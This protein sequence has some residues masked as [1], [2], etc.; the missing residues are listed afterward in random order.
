[1]LLIATFA[2]FN[3]YK[4]FTVHQ[5]TTLADPSNGRPRITTQRRDR[6]IHDHHLQDRF[7]TNRQAIWIQ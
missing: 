5:T 7:A 2:Q 1:M 6:Y 3:A 4:D